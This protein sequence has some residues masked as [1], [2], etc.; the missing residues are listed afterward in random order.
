VPD[1]ALMDRN[2]GTEGLEQPDAVH[3]ASGFGFYGSIPACCVKRILTERQAHF[4]QK[5]IFV[6]KLRDCL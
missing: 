5:T 3:E 4:A 2:C 1:F 6:Q